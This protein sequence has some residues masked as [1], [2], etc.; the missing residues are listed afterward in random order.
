MFKISSKKMV[1][2]MSGLLV[3]MDTLVPQAMTEVQ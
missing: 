2:L 3:D 1:V